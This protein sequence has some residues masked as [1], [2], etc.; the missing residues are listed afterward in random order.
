MN[1]LV[2]LFVISCIT[3][4]VTRSADRAKSS[5]VDTLP[6]E[7][8]PSRINTSLST[9]A[10]ETMDTDSLVSNV[11]FDQEK[12]ELDQSFETLESLESVAIAQNPTLRR[13]Q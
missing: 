3:G 5:S 7:S 12:T 6:R 11:Q 8:D 2:F 13:L 10:F 1:T 4:C 9:V